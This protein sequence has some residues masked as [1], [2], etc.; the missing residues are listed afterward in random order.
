MQIIT[1]LIRVELEKLGID[2]DEAL[3]KLIS[4]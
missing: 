1:W 3:E 4:S 2:V